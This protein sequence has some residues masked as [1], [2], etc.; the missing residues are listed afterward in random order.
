MLYIEIQDDIYKLHS[1]TKRQM[2]LKYELLSKYPENT[3]IR[4][5]DKGKL[6]EK[7]KL[8]DLFTK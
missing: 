4:I 2:D 8:E 5:T 6:I 3:E 1:D 7:L